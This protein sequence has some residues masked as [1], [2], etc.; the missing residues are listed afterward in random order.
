MLDLAW[1]ACDGARSV[2]DIARIV[3]AET[4]RWEPGTI[5]AWFEWAER[6][7]VAEIGS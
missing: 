5:A 6:L 3:W 4:G 1:F 7:G 2:E